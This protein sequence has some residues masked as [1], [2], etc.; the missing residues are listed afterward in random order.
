VSRGR[1][2]SI[3]LLLLVNLAV[4]VSRPDA[5]TDISASD[6]HDMIL[7][8]G[9]LIVLDV[10]EYS[11]FCGP[12]SH[13]E[14]AASLPWNSG[15]LQARL[16]ALPVDGTIIVVCAS[17]SRSHQ[18]ASFLDSRGYTDIYD[19]GGGMG[20]WRWETEACDAEPVVR[21]HKPASE[22]RINWTPTPGVQDYDLLR[23][24]I[25]DLADNVTTVDLGVTEC[26]ADDTPF[27]YHTAL[28]APFPGSPYFYLA[29]Q[30]SGSWGRS[31]QGQERVPGTDDCS[32]P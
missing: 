26:R 4:P 15:I 30:K 2:I 9:D 10:R 24:Y 17:G 28:D 14:D 27:T 32:S 6:A 12:S 18:A 5:H 16:S 29:R 20:A 25:D 13:I 21:M 19:M 7:A 1:T 22:I 8:G 3:F 31:S 23:G 11:E